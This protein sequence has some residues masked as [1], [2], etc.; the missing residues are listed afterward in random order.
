MNEEKLARL[1]EYVAGIM[2]GAR[3]ELDAIESAELEGLRRS[4]L[5]SVLE[6]LAEDGLRLFDASLTTPGAVIA[7]LERVREARGLSKSAL[8][9]RA[10]LS[11]GHLGE[12][13]AS[14]RPRPTVDTVLRLALALEVPL[15]LVEEE[16]TEPPT[17][18]PD[19][20]APGRSIWAS[21]AMATAGAMGL[22]G[23]V[24]VWLW[25]RGATS[26]VKGG[27]EP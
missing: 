17:R 14:A 9:A 4:P 15:E 8:A 20:E 1:G 24:T 21:F 5:E 3:L 22:V 25:P 16:R 19:A 26:R 11:R 18:S 2:S 7:H 13:L 23:V 6:A 12:V 27:G 10:G